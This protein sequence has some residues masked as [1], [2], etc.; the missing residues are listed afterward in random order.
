[1]FTTVAGRLPRE[2]I[3]LSIVAWL[4][5]IPS[6]LTVYYFEYINLRGLIIE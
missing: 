3:V 5:S 2:A 1:M 4:R 6:M